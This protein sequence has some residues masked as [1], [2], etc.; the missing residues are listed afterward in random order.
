[1]MRIVLLAVTAP[2]RI[3]AVAALLTAVAGFFGM[4]A[5]E[6]LS[7]GG[8]QDPATESSRA[9]RLLSEKFGRSDLQMVFLIG[10]PNSA[11]GASSRNIRRACARVR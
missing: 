1:M 9:A 7:A 6:H 8:F 5:A 10:D 11:T 3:L 4:S 2:R